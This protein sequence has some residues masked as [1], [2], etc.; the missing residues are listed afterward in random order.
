VSSSDLLEVAVEWLDSRGEQGDG[1]DHCEDPVRADL[2]DG[3]QGCVE[4]F[5]CWVSH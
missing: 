3:G 2:V 5:C 4:F 1:L